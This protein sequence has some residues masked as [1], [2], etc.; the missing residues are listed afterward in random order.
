MNILSGSIPL[1]MPYYAAGTM[2]GYLNSVIAGAGYEKLIDQ[3]G[4]GISLLD[5]QSTA[6]LFAVVLL[7]VVQGYNLVKKSSSGGAI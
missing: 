6:H 3:P 5:A 2:T 7:I 1:A 4:L